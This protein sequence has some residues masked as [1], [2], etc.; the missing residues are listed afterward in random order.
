MTRDSFQLL[1]NSLIPTSLRLKALPSSPLTKKPQI[2]ETNPPKNPFMLI[3]IRL[4]N[5]SICK[6]S[7]ILWL[8]LLSFQLRMHSLVLWLMQKMVFL[9][10]Y[11]V[12]FP[13]AYHNRFKNPL[14]SLV[15]QAPSIMMSKTP[16]FKSNI[17]MHI[18]SHNIPNTA[19]RRLTK[20]NLV[21]A[22]FWQWSMLLVNRS[23]SKKP[24]IQ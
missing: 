19:P 1:L 3:R 16:Q 11:K 13:S 10:L 12:L 4:S 14:I 6:H 24:A 9:V 23:P 18:L 5:N 17:C 22:K 20:M 7:Q 15:P 2:W 21:L 8:K